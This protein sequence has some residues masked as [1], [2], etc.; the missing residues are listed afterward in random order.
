M[1][2]CGVFIFEFELVLLVVCG[3]GLL[4]V[5]LGKLVLVI[6]LLFGLLFISGCGDFDFEWFIKFFLCFV[7]CFVIYWW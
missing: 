5:G 3:N 2:V 7:F 6:G 4:F 1:F